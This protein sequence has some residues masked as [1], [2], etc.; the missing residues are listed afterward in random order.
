M[1]TLIALAAPLLINLAA[2]SPSI[3]Q[4]AP[5]LAPE[6]YRLVWSDEFET[7][8]LPDPAKWSYDTQANR[9]GWYNSELQ[10]YSAARL[11]NARVEDGRLIITAR[12]ERLAGMA[13]FGGQ[14]YSSARLIGRDGGQGWTYGLIE[15]RLKLPCSRGSWPAF[16]MLPDNAAAWPLGGEIDIME[17]VGHDPGVV[18]GTV[19]TGK[20]NHVQG[21]QSGGQAQTPLACEQFHTYQTLWTPESVI[22]AI[23]DRPYH[24]FANDGTGEMAAWPFDH[25]F[26]ILLNVAVGGDWGGAQGVDDAALP[27]SMEVDWVRVWQ[28]AD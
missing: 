7:P 5:A 23:D 13:D 25:P 22:F 10:Y 17:H 2:A 11:E 27:Q 15:A 18:H 6:G 28:A 4:Q 21:T 16:W 1:R 14:D 19:H 26:H 8:G 12:R 24:R 9:R 20:Y 3:A